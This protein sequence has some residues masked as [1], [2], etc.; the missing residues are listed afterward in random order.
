MRAQ[1]MNELKS[2]NEFESW[3]QFTVEIFHGSQ[4]I[5]IN[6]VI[7][8]IS[9]VILRIRSCGICEITYHSS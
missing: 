5:Y 2:Q 1:K 6:G 3:L 4:F 9:K 7:I 8:F